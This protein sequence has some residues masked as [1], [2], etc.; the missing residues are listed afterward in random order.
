MKSF[1]SSNY[2]I[3]QKYFFSLIQFMLLTQ[4]LLFCW[5]QNCLLN[6]YIL[7]FFRPTDSYFLLSLPVN[8]NLS[9]VGSN[10]TPSPPVYFPLT[11]QKQK[12]L[13]P[14]HFAALSSISLQTFLPNFV[15]L[16]CLSLQIFGNTQTG[17]F[18]ISG[19]LVNPL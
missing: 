3:T 8:P 9:G 5:K 15:F 16:P 10:F 6:K 4:L 17:V 7:I 18:S 13:Q 12:K 2:S 14:W 1:F 11:T 19:F